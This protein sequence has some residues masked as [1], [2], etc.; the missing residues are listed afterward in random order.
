M[1]VDFAFIDSG[2]G[3]LPYMEY[4]TE[5]YPRSKC[6]YV[7]DAKN[8]PYGE[9]TSKQVID[10]A[11]QLCAKIIKKFEPKVIVI[12]CN[13]MSVTALEILRKTFNVAFIGTVP[14]IKLAKKVTKNKRI[15]LLATQRSI[16]SKYT[17]KL[18][19]DFADDC[20]IF[21]RAD[22][23]LISFIEHNMIGASEEEKLEACEPAVN[24]FKEN[25][26]DTIILGCTHFIHYESQIRKLAGNNI[27]VID[28]RD[29][30]VRQALKMRNILKT[31]ETSSEILPENNI[32]NK[33]F[34]VTGFP[35]HLNAKDYEKIA[36]SFNI[37]WG[38]QI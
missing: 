12:A 26:C 9:K 10:C 18:I 31:E 33:T 7:A 5:K 29:G 38:N 15:G 11:V 27:K 8:F 14:A 13:T 25:D 1:T 21:S 22:G 20:K 28:S 30:V 17:V 3:G 19:H 4:L 34:F 24:F 36:N 2:T 32:Q 16:N 37:P 23:K 35:S 6:I